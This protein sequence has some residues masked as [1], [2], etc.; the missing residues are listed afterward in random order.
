M[1]LTTDAHGKVVWRRL[2]GATI[3]MVL[4]VRELAPGESLAFED[5]WD[6][7]TSAGVPMRPG[8]YRVTGQL[9]TDTDH[10]LESEPVSLRIIP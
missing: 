5:T 1:N 6:Q 7:R 9:L 8:E 4:Q 10:P 2:R 3:S